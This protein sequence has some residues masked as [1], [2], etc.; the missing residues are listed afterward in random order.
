[1]N[2]PGAF[3]RFVSL[4]SALIAI[5]AALLS[6]VKWLSD[7]NP[8]GLVWLY[9]ALPA[10]I[11][12]LEAA[13][14]CSFL[15]LA[16]LATPKTSNANRELA[17]ASRAVVQFQQVWV[18]LWACWAVFWAL[19]AAKQWIQLFTQPS[20]V[21]K[22]VLDGLFTLGSDAANL[23]NSLGLF[24][25]FV[26]LFEITV[27][28]N[29]TDEDASVSGT[30]HHSVYK[31][32]WTVGYAFI[33]VFI[34]AEGCSLLLISDGAS[35]GA[36]PAA[37][38]VQACNCPGTTV[39]KWITSLIGGTA[40]ALFVGRLES[41]YLGT[42]L[43]ILALLY[44]YAVMQPA[45]NYFDQKNW[46]VDVF[47]TAFL[48]AKFVMFFWVRAQIKNGRLLY[49][50]TMLRPIVKDGKKDWDNFVRGL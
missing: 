6:A 4:L 47:A 29:G 36:L 49:Y 38:A 48:I 44:L 40:L 39:F 18:Y 50:M 31:Q 13:V 34:I 46:Y 41:K 37:T 45:Y 27:Q 10:I 23:L 11:L 16:I 42:P 32:A 25:C 14:V 17:T 26:I 12:S 1:M 30:S 19:L 15:I 24:I 35:S 20:D 3:E 21:V 5:I 7:G 22:H 2:N 33:A 28:E 9:K 43:S 8:S